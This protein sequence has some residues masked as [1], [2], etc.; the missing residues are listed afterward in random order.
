MR[1]NL[2][3]S[4]AHL[5]LPEFTPDFNDVLNRAND[6]GVN[7][8][9]TIGIDVPSSKKAIELAT[10]HN[11]IFATFGIH[12]CD[13]ATA[14]DEAL[15][16]L[17][18]L[19]T[20]AKVVAIGEIGLDFY[21]KTATE[22]QQFKTFK[23]QLDLA[24]QSN[25]PIVV[26]SREAD[27]AMIPILMDWAKANPNHP[28]GVI[29]CFNGSAE[30]AKKYIDAGF[31]ISLGGYITYPSSRKNHEVYRSIPVERLL[32]ETDCP[33]LPP[34]SHRGQRNEPSYLVQTA[35][36]LAA[37]KGMPL[38]EL[39][40]ITSEN[41]KNLFGLDSI[42]WARIPKQLPMFGPVGVVKL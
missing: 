34:Q 41:T 5:D 17:T 39:A 15:R 9:I 42:S 16:E 37:I 32:I 33:F 20:C 19:A 40:G 7:T 12:P 10:T 2:I 22:E 6:A 23:F 36:V 31:Y 1:Q 29:H 24:V 4:H 11:N 35:E 8:I 38:E 25:K 26:H 18:E 28:T 3:D 30:T 13:A 27:S 14:T 21:H